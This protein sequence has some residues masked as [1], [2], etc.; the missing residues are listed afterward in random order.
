MINEK[1]DY[2]KFII[3]HQIDKLRIKVITFLGYSKFINNLKEKRI[4][5][6]FNIKKSIF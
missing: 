3:E 6:F 5:C 1:I 4:F 2:I